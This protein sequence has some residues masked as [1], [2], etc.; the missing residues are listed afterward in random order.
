MR[1]LQSRSQAIIAHCDA[2]SFYCS[3]HRVFEPSLLGQP[4][5]V[6]SNNDG[7]VIARTPELKA[8]GIAMGT[9]FFQVRSLMERGLI[10]IRS[11]NYPLYGDMSERFFSVLEQFTPEVEI[12]SIDEAF[13]RFD[14]FSVSDWTDQG[15]QIRA[16][17][18]RWTGLPIGVGIATTKTLAKLANYAAKHYPATN[19]VVDLTN[20]ARQRRL[21]ALTPVTEVWGIGRRLAQRLN[22]MQVLS[23]LNLAELDPSFVRRKFS[24]VEERLVR[25]LRGESCLPW[26]EQSDG[27]KHT[28]MCSR[29]FGYPVSTKREVG[30]ALATFVSRGCEKMRQQGKTA[31]KAQ[32]FV[33][34]DPFRQQ[35]EQYQGSVIIGL[36]MPTASTQCWLEQARKGLAQIFRQGYSYRKAGFVLLDIHPQQNVQAGSQAAALQQSLQWDL[37]AAEMATNLCAKRIVTSDIMDTI[38]NRFGR[39]TIWLAARGNGHGRWRMKQQYRSPRFTTC[40]DDVVG[41]RCGKA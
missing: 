12:Y 26:D 22:N 5:G 6:L 17:V 40:W 13:L 27:N 35:E 8:L 10:Q 23:A 31:S 2:N 34:T 3:C 28:I 21:M 19:G 9:P 14:G 25:E 11:S 7:C 24:V 37:F 29:S 1:R 20:P 30:Q 15:Q 39:N 4:L 18:R 38:N 33:R 32:V 16:R 36:P 41:V